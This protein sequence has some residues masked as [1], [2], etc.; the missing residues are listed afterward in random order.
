[1]SST[2][3]VLAWLGERGQLSARA[4]ARAFAILL[5]QDLAVIPFIALLPLLGPER[6]AHASGWMLAA[7]GVAAIALVI[8][9]SRLAGP[10]CC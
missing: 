6:T 3:I 4:G 10:S 8:V 9:I 7:K 2:A 1:M 5:F